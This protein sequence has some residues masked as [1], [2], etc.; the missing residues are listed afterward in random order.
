MTTVRIQA[1]GTNG[2]TGIHHHLWISESRRPRRIKVV[3]KCAHG[4]ADRV[5]AVLSGYNLRCDWT[6]EVLQELLRR[7]TPLGEA[8]EWASLPIRPHLDCRHVRPTSPPLSLGEV[9]R[10]Q[11]DHWTPEAVARER[12]LGYDQAGGW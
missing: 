2:R 10:L 8:C 1:I 9:Y 6:A 3:A 4:D 12:I 7:R 5:F 11:A